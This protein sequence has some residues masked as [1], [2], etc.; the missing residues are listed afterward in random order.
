VEYIKLWEES[1]PETSRAIAQDPP[2]IWFFN[3][4]PELALP[5]WFRQVSEQFYRWA[6]IHPSQLVWLSR[7]KINLIVSL[8][9]W[10][11]LAGTEA[12]KLFDWKQIH[13]PCVFRRDLTPDKIRLVAI[14]IANHLWKS[15]SNKVY[16]HCLK[17]Q[18]RTGL[19]IWGYQILHNWISPSA[20]CF[21]LLRSFW[22]N[23]SSYRALLNLK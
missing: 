1:L 20:A 23:L 22:L 15:N 16:V 19:V 5:K 7:E 21:A 9:P 18:V 12:W 3:T 17:W 13:G 4:T 6:I 8:V 2:P 10:F 11:N 14:E